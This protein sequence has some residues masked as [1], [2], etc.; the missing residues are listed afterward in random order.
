M[1]SMLCISAQLSEARGSEPST[2][3]GQTSPRDDFLKASA[4]CLI[5]GDFSK[6]RHYVV[7]ALTLYCQCKFMTSLDPVPEVYSVFGIVLRSAMRMGYHRDPKHFPNLSPFDGEMRR[8]VWML[9]RMFDLM[10][11][12][13]MGLP[14]NVK[15]DQCDT[16]PPRNISDSE[17]D[18]STSILP[19][20]R[21][22]TEGTEFVYFSLKGKIM[23]IFGKIVDEVL[24]FKKIS[25][26]TVMELD[27]ELREH[28]ATLPIYFKMKPMSQSFTD[29]SHLIMIR[30]N[31]ELH[32]QKGLCVLHRKYL[33][34]G[35]LD[36]YSRTV[37]S[38]AA[39]EI[40]KHQASL[41]HESLPGGQLYEDRWMLSSLTLTDFLLAAVVLCL[42]LSESC[43]QELSME[44]RERVGEKYR[45][46][47]QSHAICNEQ[48]S[49]SKE[50]SRVSDAMATI[51]NRI[52]RIFP[53]GTG[54][55][56]STGS[57]NKHPSHS[58]A[59]VTPQGYQ[60]GLAT[61]S[62]VD[63]FGNL[64]DG[65]EPLDWVCLISIIPDSTDQMEKGST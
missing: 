29:P 53:D 8:R 5:L 61:S 39:K 17:F 56:A 19:P 60:V 59:E 45:M 37:C 47:Q 36:P 14:S 20:S 34:Q 24:S 48:R 31:C 40:L 3:D 64:I 10:I 23:M 52:R 21:P 12:F 63:P 16:E 15:N 9:T 49:R 62:I 1:F 11:S 54:V 38:T 30:M 28:H 42:D 32:F 22:M 7:E 33:N 41:H 65:S 55:L 2:P 18:E 25:H 43:R 51:L 57:A 50:A 46:L 58:M 35:S 27:S 44:E 6:P 4:Q 26:A 13:Q